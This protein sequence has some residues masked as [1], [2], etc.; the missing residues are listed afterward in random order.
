VYKHL[1][2]AFCEYFQDVPIYTVDLHS[3]VKS[4][5]RQL[6]KPSVRCAIS[7]TTIEMNMTLN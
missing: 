5:A 1:L 3:G 7:Q 2:S 4:K 6:T